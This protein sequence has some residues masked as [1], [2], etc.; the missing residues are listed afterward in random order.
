MMRPRRFPRSTADGTP[1]HTVVI[2]PVMR[3][4]SGGL[5]PAARS[6]QHGYASCAHHFGRQV[7]LL[8]RSLPAGVG[9]PA[10][11]CVSAPTRVDGAQRRNF[12]QAF[13]CFGPTHRGVRRGT[14]GQA[15]LSTFCKRG[16]LATESLPRGPIL[17]LAERRSIRYSSSR[18]AVRF[19]S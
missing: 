10:S 12:C 11:N 14:W 6:S 19:C 8:L 5:G 9:H 13:A 2:N 15:L 1:T 16:P 4:A 18:T 7:P 3:R 17:V